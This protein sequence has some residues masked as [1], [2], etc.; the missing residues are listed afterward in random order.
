MGA[1]PPR[2][3]SPCR[4]EPTNPRNIKELIRFSS[5][6]DLIRLGTQY[7]HLWMISLPCDPQNITGGL[8]WVTPLHTPT[9]DQIHN[10]LQQL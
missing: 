10:R 7:P 2:V 5:L 4:T 6:N 9:G 1:C 8:R 3:L